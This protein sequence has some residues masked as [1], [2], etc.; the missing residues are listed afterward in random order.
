MTT[1]VKTGFYL[2]SLW[3]LFVIMMIFTI[4]IPV[5]FGPD[6]EWIVPWDFIKKNLVPAICFLFIIF[7]IWF[8]LFYV[9]RRLFKSAPTYMVKVTKLNDQGYEIM[10]F[11]AT[12]FLP[13]FDYD[14]TNVRHTIVFLFL[15]IALGIIFVK[16]NIF[17]NNPTL[18]LL[19]FKV[20]KGSMVKKIDGK[21]EVIDN[22]VLV[23]EAKL[24]LNK[25]YDYLKASDSVYYL[26]ASESR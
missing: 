17:Y 5:Y 20:Y 11:I 8:Y 25:T 23:S 18:A 13:I 9:K 14:C 12:Y 16:S 6:Y 3:L 24:E 22:V 15:Y 19:G 21:D 4:D 2:L 7:D 1:F 10:T 26:N